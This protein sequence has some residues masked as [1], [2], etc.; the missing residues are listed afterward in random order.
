MKITNKEEGMRTSVDIV[1]VNYNSTDHL[2][3]CLGSVYESL[4]ELPAR[5][6]VQDNASMDN[7]ERVTSAFPHVSLKKNRCN[8]GFS[9]AVNRGLQQGSAPLCGSLEP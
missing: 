5:I 3:Q 6:F 2:L 8:I 7:V 4:Q 1:I 9:K